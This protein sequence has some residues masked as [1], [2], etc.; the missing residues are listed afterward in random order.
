MHLLCPVFLLGLGLVHPV[1]SSSCLASLAP[2]LR[3]DCH[4]DPGASE[5]SCLARNCCWSPLK[6]PDMPWCFENVD[7]CSIVLDSQRIDC[8]PESGTNEAECVSRG[9]QWCAS[10]NTT[11]PFCFYTSKEEATCSAR[12]PIQKRIDCHPQPDAT[13]EICEAKGCFWCYTTIAN[14]PW[15]F[16]P[17]DGP[18]GYIMKG[19]PQKTALGWRYIFSRTF[20][21]HFYH[22]KFLI[23]PHRFVWY[24]C[25]SP[26][27]LHSIFI[28]CILRTLSLHGESK[29]LKYM[30]FCF[31]ISFTSK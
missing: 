21:N 1:S 7:L 26:Q 18:Y 31:L 3:K 14:V 27:R 22:L 24:T 28:C 10:E 23:W 25:L 5:A 12:F 2:H 6:T 11:A 8:H 29:G 19:S 17:A 15:C 9:C 13:Q 30:A 16:Y 20:S 4:P